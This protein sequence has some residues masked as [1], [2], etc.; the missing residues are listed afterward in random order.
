MEIFSKKN[1]KTLNAMLYVL[2]YTQPQVAL[3]NL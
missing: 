3:I 1:R 2:K